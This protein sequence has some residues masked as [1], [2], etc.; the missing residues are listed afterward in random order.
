MMIQ[1]LYPLTAHA[2]K[3]NKKKTGLI[4]IMKICLLISQDISNEDKM[5]GTMKSIIVTAKHVDTYCNTIAINRYNIIGGKV[6]GRSL[7]GNNHATH[8]SNVGI[9]EK[10]YNVNQA[11]RPPAIYGSLFEIFF[12]TFHESNTR[13]RRGERTKQQK[14]KKRTKKISKAK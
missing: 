5:Q 7:T 1:S 13:N 4:T 6:L 10:T 11:L 9:N 14:R 3:G 2:T 12:K 8:P